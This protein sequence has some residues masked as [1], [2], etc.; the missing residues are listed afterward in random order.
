MRMVVDQVRSWPEGQAGRFDAR[1]TVD[2]RK[3]EVWYK[4]PPGPAQAGEALLAATLLPAMRRG[5]SL[6]IPGEVS[7]RLLTAIPR[8]QKLLQGWDARFQRV[9]VDAHPG[10]VPVGARG[11]IGLLFSGG[12]DSFYTLLKH[13]GEINELIFV[14]GFDLPLGRVALRGEI[15]RKLRLAAAELK[16][17][18]IEVETNLR[19]FSDRHVPWE[20][21]HGAALASVALLLSPRF[22]R[23]YIAG[24]R[25]SADLVP[26]GSHPD[27]DPLWSIENMAVEH[28][29][30]EATRPEKVKAIAA[31]TTALKYLRVCWENRGGRYNCGR[32]EKC[33]RTMVSLR[34][35]GALDRCA[36]FARGLDLTAVARLVPPDHLRYHVEEN[37]RIVEQ[38]GADTLLANAL[39]QS[40]GRGRDGESH[41]H[42]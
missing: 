7:P 31:D 33:L 27:L 30:T 41:R 40:L 39:R 34:I 14:H 24:T 10:S 38:S 19:A 1:V 8:I 16:K 26:W 22:S 37:L 23:I 35:A 11:D 18:L 6:Q 42:H 12:V 29:G 20:M 15:S 9:I 21:Y 2:K 25:H 28:D 5:L 36:T 32:C 3:Q 4:I 13:R 17:P